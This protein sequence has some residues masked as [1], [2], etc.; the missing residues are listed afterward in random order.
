[1]NDNCI[2]MISVNKSFASKTV[3]H[4]I[5]LCIK[6]GEIFGLLGP[7]GAG[8]TTLIKVITGQIPMDSGTA[9][10]LGKNVT[11]FDKKMYSNFGMVLDNTGLYRR[12]SCVDNLKVFADIYKISYKEIDIVLDKVGLLDAK[13]IIVDKLSKGM[14]QRL[15]L[16]RALLHSPRILFLDEPTSGLDPNTSKQIHQIILEQK[17][18][19]TTVFLTTHNMQEAYDLCDKVALLNQGIIVEY[20]NPEEICKRYNHQNKI[21]IQQKNGNTKC[22]ENKP[23]SAAAISALFSANDV[24]SI[25]STEP[26]LETVFLELTGRKLEN[27]E[28]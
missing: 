5:S 24:S 25:H 6:K 3:L 13:K 28:F 20:G 19:G 7:S 14:K 16:A 17:E 4:D 2:E 1:M 21:V 12:M 18:K 8:K 9:N 11:S 22:F 10:V 26:N 15:V 23:S 27:D